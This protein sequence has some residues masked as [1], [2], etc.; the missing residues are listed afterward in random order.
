MYKRILFLLCVF[1][2]AEHS[3]L[4][5]WRKIGRRKNNNYYF[6]SHRTQDLCLSQNNSDR[7][8]MPFLDS[9]CLGMNNNIPPGAAYSLAS[10]MVLHYLPGSLQCNPKSTNSHYL[11]S[12][13]LNSFCSLVRV[14]SAKLRSKYKNVTICILIQLK[15]LKTLFFFFFYLKLNIP[16]CAF[17]MR[18]ILKAT[19]RPVSHQ[20][21]IFEQL[22][23]PCLN[24]LKSY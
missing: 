5:L 20:Q 8:R 4:L 6:S 15:L 11:Q 22:S 10:H 21:T 16:Y 23:S 13:H 2:T 7:C 1:E 12:R 18:E 24:I 9:A 14:M 19:G 17:Y 3:F